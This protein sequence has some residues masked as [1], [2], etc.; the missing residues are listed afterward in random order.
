MAGHLQ[1][2]GMEFLI[3]LTNHWVNRLPSHHLRR[4]WYTRVM[5]FGIHPSSSLLMGSTFDT[6]GAFTLGAHSVINEKCRL[7]NRGTLTIGR[8]VSISSEVMIL[9][10]T[11]DV[12]SPGFAGV[13]APVVI[14]DFAWI[15][16]RALI[17]PGVRIGTAAVVA[18]GAVVTA[19]VPAH[20]I[21]GGVPARPI[22]RREAEMGYEL[23]YQ[24]LFH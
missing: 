13:N 19:D 6:R 15:G 10:A 14:G 18:A 24:R 4:W 23:D 1:Y 17:L 5:G 8:S 2:V 22:G 11:H 9:T 21:V 3:Y 7:D 16:A 12:Q 20:A